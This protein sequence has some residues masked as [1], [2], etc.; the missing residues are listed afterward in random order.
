MASTIQRAAT[1]ASRALRVLSH[2]TKSLVAHTRAAQAAATHTD[3][4]SAHATRCP[5]VRRSVS[6]GLPIAVC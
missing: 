1:S 3:H 2:W 5:R 4:A 6:K